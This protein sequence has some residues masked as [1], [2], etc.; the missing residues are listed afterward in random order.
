MTVMTVGPALG[1]RVG[2]AGA[3]AGVPGGAN[4]SYALA[5]PPLFHASPPRRPH[6]I[7]LP[8]RPSST[9][10]NSPNAADSSSCR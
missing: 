1:S 10:S 6:S 9:T 2:L 8:S 4:A 7:R 5:G 3:D